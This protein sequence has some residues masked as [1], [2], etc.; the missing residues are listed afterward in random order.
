MNI[1]AVDDESGALKLLSEAIK[2]V[3]PLNKGKL[4]LC[5]NKEEIDKAIKK[6][7]IDLAFLDI[8]LGDISGLSI[9]KELKKINPL[10]NI[11]FVT[12]YNNYKGDALS[13]HASGYI[14]KPVSSEDVLK[15]YKNLLHPIEE[16]TSLL[17]CKT[18]GNFEVK[19]INQFILNV[20]KLK[21]Y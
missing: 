9:A 3:I 15:E 11:I 21:N 10:V 19:I 14:T 1:L 4:I 18:F 8:N 13:L 12:G 20:V 5:S 2:E 6:D 16:E 17:C 7:K